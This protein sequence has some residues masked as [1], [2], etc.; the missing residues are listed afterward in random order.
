MGVYNTRIRR[1]S[2]TILIL[3]TLLVVGAFFYNLSL[4]QGTDVEWIH[5]RILYL[6]VMLLLSCTFFLLAVGI[7]LFSADF[8]S[9]QRIVYFAVLSVWLVILFIQDTGIYRATN[10]LLHI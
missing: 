7:L 10:P 4:E 1:P 8:S 3:Y 2:F 5:E 9:G 6:S